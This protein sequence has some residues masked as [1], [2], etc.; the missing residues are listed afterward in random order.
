MEIQGYKERLVDQVIELYLLTFGALLIEGSKWCGKTWTSRHHS[1]S[2]FLLSDSKNNF[3]NRRRAERNPDLILGGDTPRLIDEWQEVPAI[4][5]AVRGR[6]D[7]LN[8][9]G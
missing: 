6:V 1:K 3:N 4:W 8:L 9:K 2:E 5:D 7:R